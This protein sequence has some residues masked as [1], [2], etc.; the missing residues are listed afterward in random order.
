MLLA[1]LIWNS[2]YTLFL[3]LPKAQALPVMSPQQQPQHI[4][5]HI[6]QQPPCKD[7]TG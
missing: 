4:S 3:A 2:F 7:L 1:E 5:A 6:R